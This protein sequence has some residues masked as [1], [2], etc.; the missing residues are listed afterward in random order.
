MG[1]LRKKRNINLKKIYAW[2]ILTQKNIFT[3]AKLLF[4]Q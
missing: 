4:I 1:F 2:N 3:S